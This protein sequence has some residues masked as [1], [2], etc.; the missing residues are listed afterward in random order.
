MTG[1]LIRTG[2][3]NMLYILSI[4]NNW[5]PFMMNYRHYMVRL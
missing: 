2:W 3:V 4:A 1:I 5:I